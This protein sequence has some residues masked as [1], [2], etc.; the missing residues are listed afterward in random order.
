MEELDLEDGFLMK[1]R[2]HWNKEYLIP[3]SG[4]LYLKVIAKT[5]ETDRNGSTFTHFYIVK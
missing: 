5:Q 2:Y 1:G 4:G 3:I